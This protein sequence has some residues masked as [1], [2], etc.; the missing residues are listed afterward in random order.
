MKP[1]DAA[2][3]MK[4]MKG[5]EIDG[6]PLNIDMAKKRAEG[7]ESSNKRQKTFGDAPSEPVIPSSLQILPLAP[8]KIWSATRLV[9]MAMSLP[10]ACLRILSL[11]KL[12]DTGMFNSTRLMEP[13][14]PWRQ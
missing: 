3:A 14:P 12:R 7:A 8:T 10:F 13:P 6:R 11:A 5:K 2:K 9:N 4:E 1:A